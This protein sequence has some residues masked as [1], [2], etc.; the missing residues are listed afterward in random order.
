MYKY[1]II[2]KGKKK[3]FLTFLFLFPELIHLNALVLI[4]KNILRQ[5]KG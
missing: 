4:E 2:K 5:K 1:E 3:I